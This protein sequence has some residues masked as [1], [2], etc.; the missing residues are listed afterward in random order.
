MEFEAVENTDR[1]LDWTLTAA[2]KLWLCFRLSR[3]AS[4]SRTTDGNPLRVSNK[5][6][7]EMRLGIAVKVNTVPE[8]RQTV[9]PE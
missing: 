8:G 1:D 2:R 9:V 7:P 4:R 5:G 6:L 3:K